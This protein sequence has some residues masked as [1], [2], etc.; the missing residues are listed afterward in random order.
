MDFVHLIKSKQAEKGLSDLEVSKTS[1]IDEY[2]YYNLIKYRCYLSR[3]AYFTLSAVFGLPILSE[4]EIEELLA[5][6]KKLVGSPETNLYVAE[7]YGDIQRIELLEKELAR[8]K[9]S[10]EGVSQKN[11]VINSQYK[12]IEKLKKEIDKLQSDIDEKVRDA[13]SKGITDGMSKIGNMQ[14][15][16]NNLL[17]DALNEEY[18]E[19][20]DK[21][22]LA[23]K[24]LE[25]S[26]TNLYREVLANNL[27]DN[28]GNFEKPL[29]LSKEELGLSL[30]NSLICDVLTKY[31]EGNNTIENV[32][33]LFSI[34]ELEVENIVVNYAIVDKNGVKSYVKRQ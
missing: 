23:L 1:G 14:N 4:L 16:H 6:N 25:L 13:Y 34:S 33:K 3:V 9:S 29:L 22:E 2:T 32:A 30:D 27:V 15:A 10:H 8:L 5:E 19:K 24:K 26:Y 11:V 12:E 31:Y 7:T 21:L 28:I 18:T 20:I 17:I